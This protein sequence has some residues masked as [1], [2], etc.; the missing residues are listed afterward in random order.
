MANEQELVMFEGASL[1]Q[2]TKLFRMDRRTISEKI[3]NLAPS[4]KRNGSNIYLVHEVAP[5]LVKPKFDVE[6]TIKR[7]HHHDLPKMLTKEFWAGQRSK[8][9]FMLKAGDLWPTADVVKNVGE[10]MKLVSMSAK[11]AVDSVERQ[12]ELTPRQRT[13]IRNLMDGMLKD[14]RQQV[15]RTFENREGGSGDSDESL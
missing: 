11:L 3:R 13:I 9:E 6:E 7:M 8:Q 1:H 10:L 2:L 14:L 4:G 15:I 12:T 5:L